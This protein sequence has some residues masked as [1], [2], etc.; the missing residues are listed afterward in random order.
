LH[1][2]P[3]GPSTAGC[4]Q[5]SEGT[6]APG[7]PSL[8][9]LSLGEARESESPAAATERHRN[10]AKCELVRSKN[11]LGIGRFG[12]R[13]RIRHAF[14]A[15]CGCCAA[16]SRSDPQNPATRRFCK[17]FRPLA[18]MIRAEA[19][20]K[21]VATCKLTDLNPIPNPIPYPSRKALVTA[22]RSAASS[23]SGRAIV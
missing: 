15:P 10:Q 16:K 11:K 20:M 21:I 23:G 2:T 8:C 6:Q 19:A 4:P 9:L 3:A 13:A 7:S 17:C 1:E 14:G 22:P 5:R 12:V 18:Q